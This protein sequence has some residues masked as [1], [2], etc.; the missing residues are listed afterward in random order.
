MLTNDSPYGCT[1]YTFD[2][3]N[4]TLP[5][6]LITDMKLLG[7]TWLRYQLPWTFIEQTPGLYTWHAL[8]SVVAT[9]NSNNINLCYVIQGSPQFYDQQP[10]ANTRTIISGGTTHS[11]SITLNTAPVDLS[12]NTPIRLSGGVGKPEIIQTARNYSTGANP[13]T[14]ASSITGNNRTT[15]QW[16]LYP[17]PQSTANF[18]QAT[19]T[20]YNGQNGFGTIQAFEIGNEEYDSQNT[21]GTSANIY[22]DRAATYYI[23]VLPVVSPAIRA[24]NPNAI[25]G[26]CAIWWSQL[27]HVSNFLTAIYTASPTMKNQFDYVNF[28][29]YPFESG[30]SD[31]VDVDR[32]CY[33]AQPQSTIP[34]FTQEWQALQSVMVANGDTHQAHLGHRIW[35]VYQYQSVLSW[36]H[37]YGDPGY[38]GP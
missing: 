4:G 25:I 3:V 18:A 31:M 33:G 26:M 22:A 5:S 13:V 32:W 8:D 29:Y 38:P 36:N 15:V 30:S 9:C 24:A 37:Q 17:D 6:Q 10:G 7:L 35:L 14:L 34:S 28:H 1:F 12:P 20:R 23:N 16:Y 19:A 21:N 11:T 2:P 27:P